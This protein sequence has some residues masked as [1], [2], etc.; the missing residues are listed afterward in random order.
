MAA[1]AKNRKFLNVLFVPLVHVW[2]NFIQLSLFRG[3]KWLSEQSIEKS[4]NL[5]PFEFTSGLYSKHLH[6]N[7][8]HNALYQNCT[9][10]STPMSKI[11]TRAKNRFFF[12]NQPEP[13]LTWAINGLMALMF[14]TNCLYLKTFIS[15][16]IVYPLQVITMIRS[17]A[18]NSTCI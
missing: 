10:G 1:T 12:I 3:I 6:T 11:A 18:R 9:N 8:L 14:Q 16:H 2:Y 7:V 5:Y 13:G 17:C 4:L 15:I